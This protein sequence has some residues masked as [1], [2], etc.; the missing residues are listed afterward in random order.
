MTA[1][2]LLEQLL[3][4]MQFGVMLFLLSAGLTLVFG[5]MNFINLAHGS[6][7]MLGAYTGIAAYSASGSFLYGALTGVLCGG[8]VAFLLDTAVFRNLYQKDHLHQVLGT[9]GLILF[10][11]AL[12]HWIWGPSA[13]FSRIPE[14]LDFRVTLMGELEYPA[15]RLA[16]SLVGLA[17]AAFLYGLIE[18]SRIGMLI[19]AG[20]TDR[21]MVAA[22]GVNIRRLYTV[23]FVLGGVLAGLAG[24]AASPLF[25]VEA[26]MG[27]NVLILMFVVIII[28]G[29][30]SVRGAFIAAILVGLVD[31]LGRAF[32]RIVLG[33]LFPPDVAD[34]TAPA[35][36]SMLVYV[37]MVAVLF[38]K[39]EGLFAGRSA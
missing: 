2:S 13:L 39:P 21:D 24:V 6:L 25:A 20:A 11:N 37:M 28:G 7:Y 19:R 12:V 27:E 36:A 5:V 30:G 31:T 15:Y 18:H 17:V 9:F 14:F 29:I 23:V 4:S 16:V 34:G 3:N 8:A 33:G 38:L 22:L 26:G 1:Q 32:M 35:L 10:F